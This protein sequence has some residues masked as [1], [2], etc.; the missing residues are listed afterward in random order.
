M[1]QKLP[2]LRKMVYRPVSKSE[3]TQTTVSESH[4]LKA[5]QSIEEYPRKIASTPCLK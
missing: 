5:K 4:Y 2:I 3:L 1:V